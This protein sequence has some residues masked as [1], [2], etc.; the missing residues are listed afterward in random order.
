MKHAGDEVRRQLYER[1]AVLHRYEGKIVMWHMFN[2]ELTIDGT[3]AGPMHCL[4]P[5]VD[6]L[7]KDLPI[8]NN[9]DHIETIQAIQI[10]NE[11][12]KMRID[13]TKVK[14]ISERSEELLSILI[15]I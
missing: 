3:G 7:H 11:D 13:I 10:D 2:K 12:G 6:S 5:N 8:A 1:K 14:I 15:S 4:R 9:N